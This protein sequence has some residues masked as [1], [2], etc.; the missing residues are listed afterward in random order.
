MTRDPIIA[1]GKVLCGFLTSSAAV[2]MA[3]KPIYAKNMIAAPL[4]MPI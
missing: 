4:N 2:V 3:S 1:M